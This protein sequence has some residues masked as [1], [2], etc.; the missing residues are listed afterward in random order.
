MGFFDRFKTAAALLDPMTGALPNPT[1]AVSPW[2]TGQLSPIVAAAELA[3]IQAPNIMTRLEAMKVP[4]VAKGRAILHAII[5]GSPL[6]AYNDQGAL[7]NQP[8]WLYRS[9]NGISPFLRMT[10]ILD[11]IY[12]NEASVLA[13]RRSTADESI[14]D[15]VNVPYDR[16][17]VRDGVI[18]VD[19]K[20]ADASQ[21]IYIP[22]PFP[23]LLA[24]AADTLRAARDTDR[25]WMKRVKSPIP[26]TVIQET[27]D[28]GGMDNTEATAYTKAAATALRDSEV[29]LFFLPAYL[30]ADFATAQVTTDLFESGRN[31]IRID[32]ANFINFPTSLL[33]G[34]VSEASLTYS[35]QE[36]RRDEVFDYSVRYWKNPIE[37][38]LSLD[39]V[40]P[41]G[42]RVRFDFSDTFTTTPSPTGPAEQD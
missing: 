12:F 38:A 17:A 34:T 22:G 36:G 8:T 7:P 28:M 31:A 15:A 20:P 14:L 19:E 33:D 5:A 26:A 4:A 21:V 24:I 42:Q 32:I 29:P 3:G 39:N 2:A 30:K 18:Y 13:V 6:R 40:V 16:W 1:V 9:D 35:T 37:Q 25:A 23:G 41:R 27:E 10:N 11:D